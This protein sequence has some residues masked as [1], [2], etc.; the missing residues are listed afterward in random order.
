MH[1][2]DQIAVVLAKIEAGNGV[3][4]VKAWSKSIWLHTRE[5][6]V[7]IHKRLILTSFVKIDPLGPWEA[8]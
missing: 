8:P 7:C 4:D 1:L 2:F 3:I 6:V 5:S